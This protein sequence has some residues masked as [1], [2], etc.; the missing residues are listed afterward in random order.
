M[1]KAASNCENACPVCHLFTMPPI[2]GESRLSKAS[3]Q[4][5]A[6]GVVQPRWVNRMTDAKYA[7]VYGITHDVARTYAL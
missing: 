2:A 4:G 1:D 7:I 3:K 6:F 5:F